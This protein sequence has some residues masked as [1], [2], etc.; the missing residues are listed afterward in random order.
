[1][2]PISPL[3]HWVAR[4]VTATIIAVLLLISSSS[5]VLAHPVLI[6]SDPPDA[7]TLAVS[8]AEVR[9]FFSERIAEKFSTARVVN[10]RGETVEGVRVIT[11]GAAD[12][13]LIVVPPPLRSGAYIVEWKVLS[14]DDGHVTQGQLVFGVGQT[15]KGTSGA[16]RSAAAVAPMDALFGWLNLLA[17]TVVVGAMATRRLMVPSVAGFGY[18]GRPEVIDLERAAQTLDRVILTFSGLALAVGVALFA[19]QVALVDDSAVGPASSWDT[20]IQLIVHSRWGVFWTIREALYATICLLVVRSRASGRAD[21]T[22]GVALGAAALSLLGLHALFGHAAALPEQ[23]VL[24][25]VADTLHLVAA[26][27]WMGGLGSV[28]IITLPLVRSEAIGSRAAARSIWIRFSGY[29]A[30]SL[31]VLVV[32]GLFRAG[33]EVATVDALLTTAYGR[34]LLLKAILVSVGA[35]FGLRNAMSLHSWIRPPLRPLRPAALTSPH[36]ARARLP[37]FARIE[38]LVGVGVVALA[39]VLSATPVALGPQ[40][41]APASPPQNPHSRMVQD[42]LVNVDVK[43]NVPGQNVITVVAAST[44]RPRPSPIYAVDVRFTYLGADPAAAAPTVV[45]AAKV[46]PYQFRVG[47]DYLTAPGSWT[48]DV[49]ARRVG[50]PDTVASFPWTVGPAGVEHRV[51]ISDRPIQP[52]LTIAAGA[53]SL[54]FVIAVAIGTWLAYRGTASRWPEPRRERRTVA[55]ARRS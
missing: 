32:T 26:S 40:F 48:I 43:P 38:F 3:R 22:I 8:P 41:L 55:P 50:M 9:L 37:R 15:V 13:M 17:L 33:Q 45:R 11:A 24:G 30:V 49:V 18:D 35:V 21:R 7:A 53:L 36:V 47:G 4:S 52:Y 20:S 44:R 2:A 25:I 54:I 23:A 29:A 6:R 27:I 16:E 14:D 10:A 34:G 28:L 42:V 12:R 1:M 5:R 51:W 19:R 46:D 31:G 39:G